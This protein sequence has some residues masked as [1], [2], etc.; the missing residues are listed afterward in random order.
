[1]AGIHSRRRHPNVSVLR[2]LVQRLRETGSLHESLQPLPG[3]ELRWPCRPA[4]S[5]SLYWPGYPGSLLYKGCCHD[6][7]YVSNYGRIIGDK[8]RQ[9]RKVCSGM[10]TQP[11]AGGRRSVRPRQ[12]QASSY[13]TA[14]LPQ[15][16]SAALM[17]TD[18]REDHTVC[19]GKL[20]LCG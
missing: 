3:I 20:E 18:T 10:S 11:A 2:R 7:K 9:R 19:A 6:G 12:T 16:V 4:C 1:M 17:K 5:R 14:S 15:P 8:F 13:T